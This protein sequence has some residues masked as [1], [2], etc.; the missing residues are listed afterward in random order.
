MNN[1]VTETSC[2]VVIVDDDELTLEYLRRLWRNVDCKVL[3]FTDSM[4]ALSFLQNHIAPILIL[5]YRMP[6]L[7]GLELLKRLFDTNSLGDSQIYLCSAVELPRAIGA[8]AKSIGAKL[9]LKE[10]L[11][12]KALLQ[13]LIDT[14]RKNLVIQ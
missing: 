6:R 1:A 8:E 13:K 4:R 14:N 11:R 7:D 2:D 9:I 5:D 12:D 10:T 3:Y